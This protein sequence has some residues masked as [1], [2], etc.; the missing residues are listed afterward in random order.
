LS[1]Q[2][3][4]DLPGQSRAVVKVVVENH[5]AALQTPFHTLSIPDERI[6]GGNISH[7]NTWQK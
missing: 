4:I 3:R 2:I 1:L 7:V 5:A 6:I